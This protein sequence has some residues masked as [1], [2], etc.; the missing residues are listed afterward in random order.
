MVPLDLIHDILR[1]ETGAERTGNS[2]RIP[3]PEG[4]TVVEVRHLG[5]RTHDGITVE[6]CATVR[7]ELPDS[8]APLGTG[9]WNRNG[10]QCS[11][12]QTG[13]VLPG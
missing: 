4:D 5:L 9:K 8:L 3:S 12:D 13:T 6:E 10:S 1:L 2:V 7:T 11:H